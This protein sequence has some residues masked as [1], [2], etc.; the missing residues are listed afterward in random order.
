MRASTSASAWISRCR[1]ASA[2]SPSRPFIWRNACRRWP[3]RLRRHQVGEAFDRGQIELAV[4]EGAAGEFAGLGRAQALDRAERGQRRRDHRAAA[5][6]LQL[7]HVLAGLALRRRKPQRQRLVDDLFAF[8]GS[9]TRPSAAWRGAGI[10]PVSAFSA[11]PA[12][13]PEMRTTAIAAGARPEERAKMV[14]RSIRHKWVEANRGLRGK[15]KID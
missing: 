13:G 3:S 4:L 7:G 12:R 5:V 14:S 8:A 15:A 11:A 9:R 6:Q 1:Q 2:R 10:L